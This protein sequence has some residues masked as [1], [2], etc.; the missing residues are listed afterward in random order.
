MVED[1][2][3]NQEIMYNLETDPQMREYLKQTK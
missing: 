3:G 1:L 2:D